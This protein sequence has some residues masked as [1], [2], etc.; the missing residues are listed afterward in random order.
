MLIGNGRLYGGDFRL[1]PDADPRDGLLDVCAFP[2]IGWLRLIRCA[3][4]LL[5]ANRLPNGVAN[6]LRD[7]TFRFESTKPAALE[8]D[9]EFAGH[10]PVTFGVD[11]M[12]LRVIVPK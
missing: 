4:P 3:A 9:G 1:F 7:Q 6:R 2:S 11:P 10:L 5:L 8:V 12:Q